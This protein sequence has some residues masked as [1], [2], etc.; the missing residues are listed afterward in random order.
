M[1]QE[2]P[3][4]QTVI[5]HEE[6]ALDSYLNRLLA[7]IPATDSEQDEKEKL[8]KPKLI[9]ELKKRERIELPSQQQLMFP[10]AVMPDY[11]QNEF[12]AL[13]FR[14]G[15][16]VLATPLT[17]LLRTTAFNGNL[18]KIPGQA[19]WFL[20]LI[21]DQDTKFGVLDTEQLIVGNEADSKRDQRK[22]PFRSLLLTLSGDWGLACDEVLSITKVEPAKVRWRTHRRNKPWLIG[23]I[24]NEL[25]A[26]IDINEL[27]ST[28]Y[29]KTKK[30][31]DI[32]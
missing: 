22:N 18:T 26:I 9:P 17:G 3:V 5:Q 25:A 28:R 31:Y 10:L 19:E 1:S 32:G 23:T 6:I 20:G 4:L 14:V 11:S 8:L 27:V 7:K 30:T 29:G 24:I 13:F 16:L 12:Q 15:H 2:Y 21:E